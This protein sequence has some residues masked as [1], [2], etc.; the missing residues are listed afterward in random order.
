[1][2]KYKQLLFAGCYDGFIYIYNTKMQKHV[3]TIAGPGEGMVLSLVI[4]KGMVSFFLYIY[5]ISR[6]YI[7]GVETNIVINGT[8]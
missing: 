6:Y 4:Y 1:M 5:S 7:E 2:V 8:L 3:A